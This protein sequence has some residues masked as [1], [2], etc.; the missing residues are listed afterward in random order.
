LVSNIVKEGAA[1]IFVSY[2]IDEI[3][4]ITDRATVLRDGNLTIAEN[5]LLAV[6][7]DF[8][9]WLRLDWSAM[10][11][12]AMQLGKHYDVRPNRPAKN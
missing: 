8:V 6:L 5:M 11:G 10:T 3:R 1:V 12:R 4:E 2:D 9:R 7:R